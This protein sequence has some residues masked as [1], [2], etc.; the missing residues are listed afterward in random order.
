MDGFRLRM[1]SKLDLLHGKVYILSSLFCNQHSKRPT[2]E[3]LKDSGS[4][5]VLAILIAI[6]IVS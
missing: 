5:I 1:G 3:V 4:S 2:D 6:I